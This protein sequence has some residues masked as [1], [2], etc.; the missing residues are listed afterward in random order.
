MALT[1]CLDCNATVKAD[2]LNC[3]AC[4]TR[5]EG[6]RK[7]KFG[8]GFATFLSILF[9]TSALLT[10]SS[11]FLENGPSFGKCLMVSVVLL[12]ARTSAGGMTKQEDS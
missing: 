12:V 1:R 6:R 3:Y 7:S 4:G 11:L 9:F 5:V 10:V 2:E 8:A